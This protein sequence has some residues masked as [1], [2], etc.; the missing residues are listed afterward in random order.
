[1]PYTSEGLVVTRILR[2]P[3][4]EVFPW[5]SAREVVLRGGERAVRHAIV[6]RAEHVPLATYRGL[7]VLRRS[8]VGR[9][10][11]VDRLG[12]GRWVDYLVDRV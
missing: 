12:D 11:V 7:G 4:R 9:V 5:D 3:R 1:M 8:D 2:E 10:L 6:V